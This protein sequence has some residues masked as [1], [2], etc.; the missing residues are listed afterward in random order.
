VTFLG[1][2]VPALLVA[3]ALRR[4]FAPLPWSVVGIASS[5]ALLFLHG[6]V[7][8]TKV[9]VPVDEVMRGYPY[10][11]IVGA[12]TPRN[13]LTND[14]VKQI[15]PWMQVAREELR[16]GRAPL[17]NRYHFSGY[18]LLGNGQSAPFAPTFLA[19][20]FVPL[21][22]QLVAMAGLK[23]FLSIVFAWLFLRDEGVSWAAALC[24]AALY[25]FSVFMTVY[26]YYPM[27]TVTSLLPAA[28]FAARGCVNRQPQ[29][30]SRPHIVLL[31]I[32]TAA[33]AAGGHPESALH[34]GIACAI[35]I[36]LEWRNP[37][38]AIVAAVFGLAVSAPAWVPVV[39]QALISV[40]AAA[41][42]SA[43][44]AAMHPYLA[45]TL[46]NP[47]AFGN[48]ARGT[49]NWI[50]NYSI[51]AS[52]YLGLIPLALLFAARTRRDWQ[53][54]ATCVLLFLVAMNW[55][56]LGRTINAIPPMSL[57]AQDRLRFVV[58]FFAAVLAARVVDRLPRV[59]TFVASAIICAAAAWLVQM[60][61]LGMHAAVGAL[62]LAIFA[63]VVMARPR[64]APVAALVVTVI[65]LF[66][67]N[68]HF[69]VLTSRACFQPPMPILD[70]LRELSQGE[71][72][73]IVGH[74]WTFLPNAA[75]QYGVE[76]IRGHDPMA[77][78]SYATFFKSIAVDDPSSDVLRVQDVEHPALPFL[79]TRFLLTDPSFTP[80]ANWLLRYEGPDGKLYESKRWFRRFFAPHGDARIGAIVQ[81]TPT[82]LRVEV[83]APRGALISSSMVFAPGW[84]VEGALST[85]RLHDT[86]LA[87]RVGPG[88][89]TITVRY[90]PRSFYWSCVVALLALYIGVHATIQ[91]GRHRDRVDGA[92]VPGGIRS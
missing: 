14:T 22:H 74:D 75:A 43:P 66:T 70:A 60:K 11:G 67:F 37:L 52:T 69:N 73:R 33:V 92:R 18:P 46:L 53:L 35:V 10:R 79:G 51:V 48:P 88:Q 81:E 90:A 47:D 59:R 17:W 68:A 13:P 15:L 30:A 34:I 63:V 20:L 28:A 55:T 71:P 84:R 89:H 86:F 62:A 83:D 65:E 8:T 72:S 49:W 26:L 9:P 29:T 61:S 54:V 56:F 85:L 24:G 27:T 12:V 42:A 31:A 4:W 77:L 25:T 32:V 91:A 23:L 57:V 87:F 58:L 36:A 76:D 78:A 3:L 41:L 2:A 45:W 21:P 80:S 19:T 16:N 1:I 82:K 50:Y 6:A 40:R 5:L 38:P 7:F 44:H 64:L 39:E